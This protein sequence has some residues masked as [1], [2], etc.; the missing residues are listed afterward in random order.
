MK[1]PYL[2]LINDSSIAKLTGELNGMG[3]GQTL[4]KDKQ[5]QTSSLSRPQHAKQNCLAAI[6]LKR[7]VNLLKCFVLELGAKGNDINGFFI[8]MIALEVHQKGKNIQQQGFA[9]GHPLNY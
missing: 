8:V 1:S 2:P 5:L 3:T 4:H 9:N 7:L 6:R